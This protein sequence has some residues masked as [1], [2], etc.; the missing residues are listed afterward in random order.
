VALGVAP[1]VFV[2]GDVSYDVAKGAVAKH[3][4]GVA[5]IAGE[6][7]VSAYLLA[8][9]VKLKYTYGLISLLFC[10]RERLGKNAARPPLPSHPSLPLRPRSSCLS[11]FIGRRL[12]RER[13]GGQGLDRVPAAQGLCAGGRGAAQ[14]GRGHGLRRGGLEEG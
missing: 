10:M 1:S 12:D 2:G 8:P 5:Y 11:S 6:V 13:R 9:C 7:S 4:F 14:A 3:S